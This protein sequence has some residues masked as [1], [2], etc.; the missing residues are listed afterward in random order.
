MY[1]YIYIYIHTC[2][3]QV[4]LAVYDVFAV[5]TPLGPLKALVEL[6]QVFVPTYALIRQMHTLYTP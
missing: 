6:S 4:S 3:L 5:L 1:I 2:T